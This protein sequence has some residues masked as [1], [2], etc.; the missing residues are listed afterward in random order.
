MLVSA[1]AGPPSAACLHLFACVQSQWACPASLWIFKG[2]PGATVEFRTAGLLPLGIGRQ[3]TCFPVKRLLPG[4]K[5]LKTLW[6]IGH[7]GSPPDGCRAAGPGPPPALLLVLA[8]C[9]QASLA[10][11]IQRP[12]S[13]KPGRCWQYSESGAQRGWVA[14]LCVLLP[15]VVVAEAP[16]SPKKLQMECSRP[17]HGLGKAAVTSGPGSVHG[18]MRF[19]L[20]GPKRAWSCGGGRGRAAAGALV[21]AGTSH[22]AW[23]WI[24]LRGRRKG[25]WAICSGDPRALPRRVKHRS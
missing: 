2:C 20:G 22:S 12:G 9:P 4:D 25:T 10:L 7:F 14:A 24:V 23:L 18:R 19:L 15:S 5:G 17:P 1:R 21:L 11:Q 6:S 3:E 8:V 13:T 16:P